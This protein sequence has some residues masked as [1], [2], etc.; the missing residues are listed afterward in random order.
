MQSSKEGSLYAI[1]CYVLWGV[2]PIYFRA[3]EPTPASQILLHR[4]VWSLLFLVLVLSVRRQWGWLGP[5]L[6]DPRLIA[7]FL[8]S[9][10]MLTCN[11]FVYIWA[12]N[13]GHVVDASLGYFINP[14]VN[15]LLGF[16]VLRERLRILQWLAILLAVLG[17]AWLTLVAG[18]PPW[19][20]LTLAVS[21]AFYG[22][23]RKTA[24][25]GALE[26]LTLET[27]VLAP[28]ALGC[29]VW[30]SVRHE[31]AFS[32]LSLGT[33]W[34]LVAAGPITAIPL[35]M[36]G[37]A[38]RRIPFSLLGLLQYICPTLQ[39]L[40]GVLLYGEPFSRNRAL[41]YGA[42]WLALIAYSAEAVW[43][44]RRRAP[45]GLGARSAEP[46]GSSPLDPRRA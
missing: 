3:L 6:G 30:L 40:V 7:R 26:A 8:A 35:L 28:F 2:F 10:L 19:I 29:L 11:W 34:L 20:G 9:A 25:L 1:A 31:N 45:G 33:R 24:P 14:L 23:L 12:C 43:Q 17:V 13:S 32:E 21:F 46:G 16:L 22:L 27:L 44:S 39:L 42:I 41:G 36:F 38:A 4:V 37:A 5:A 15:V 18:H